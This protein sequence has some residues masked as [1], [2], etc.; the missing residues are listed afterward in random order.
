MRSV[1]SA[2]MSVLPSQ[3]R[4]VNDVFLAGVVQN[5]TAHD[6]DRLLGAMAGSRL[7]AGTSKGIQIC[8]F[9]N[10]GLLAI[11][12]PVRRFTLAHRIPA[13]FMLP[14]KISA[15]QRKCCLTHTI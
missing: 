3:E 9:P 4:I 11:T 15:T 5:G 14:V 1:S 10:G 7:L 12:A 6:L 8:N 2:A 13:G